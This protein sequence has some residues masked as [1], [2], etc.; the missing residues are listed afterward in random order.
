MKA[1]EGKVTQQGAGIS[2]E[3]Y[4][5][6]GLDLKT[7]QGVAYKKVEEMVRKFTGQW[8]VYTGKDIAKN[9]PKDWM[10]LEL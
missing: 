4:A 10:R 3:F 2:P 8:I 1:R 9:N 6:L 5:T 7:R